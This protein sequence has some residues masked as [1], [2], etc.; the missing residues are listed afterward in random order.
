MAQN[1]P[2]KTSQ[3]ESDVDIQ[4]SYTWNNLESSIDSIFDIYLKAEES[5]Q[6]G[7]IS[8]VSSDSI[9]LSKAY[10]VSDLETNKTFDPDQ[11]H[12]MVASVAK[13]ITATAVFKLMEQ[14]K[15]QLDQPVKDIIKDITIQNPFDQP[16]LV[17]HLLTHTAGFD[18]SAM[19]DEVKD[20][21]KLAS[22]KDH[23]KKRLPPVVWEPGKFYNYS[24][25]GMVLLAYVVECASGL[26][27]D[28]FLR[29]NVYR[30][31][32]MD[33]SGFDYSDELL[34]NLFTRYRWKENEKRGLFLDGSYG[35]KYTNQIGASGFKTTGYDMA[36]FMQMY[37][38]KGM[39]QGIKVLEE[40]TIENALKPQF[41]YHD[42]MDS[43]QGLTW[44]IRKVQ[45]LTFYYHSG[46][47][48]GLESIL[49]MVPDKDI[50]YFFAS[51]NN[52]AS[53][54]KFELRDFLLNKL[55]SKEKIEKKYPSDF[56][57]DTDLKS[58]AGSYQ[59]MNDGYT[60]IESVSY[61]FGD[62]RKVK[63]EG[64]QFFVNGNVYEEVDKLLFR[65]KRDSLL[66]SFVIND[67]RAH[68]STGYGTFR[69]LKWYESPSLHLPAMMGCFAIFLS[70]VILWPIQYFR[71]RKKGN[72]PVYKVKRTIGI[73]AFLILF[74]F[75]LLGTTTQGLSL[76]FGAPSYLY[77]YFTLPIL[78]A[79]TFLI[80]LFKVPAFFKNSSV[81]I[82]GKVHFAVVLLAIVACLFIYNYY[83]LLGY[84]F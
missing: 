14:G 69:Q 9:L 47:D 22:L 53:N 26:P 49:V 31:L 6:G 11:T 25:R 45:D 18:D 79:L 59:Y 13:L 35:I 41:F 74:F 76:K 16:I 12:V 33:K 30:P 55:I 83:N 29:E 36:N 20:R 34:N 8:I 48:V 17:R 32:N 39:F 7:V 72:V 50:A 38:K 46:D 21:Q 71:K 77:F 37:L 73:A 81:S 54:L 57:S 56:V 28:Q 64:D 63:L 23:L 15:I 1:V 24:N 75:I 84:N 4:K 62:V 78:G 82:L 44:R 42:L 58:L 43:K 67:N 40:E 19:G 3:G 66:V 52:V 5:L 80:G 2:Q 27:F 65:R 60:T 10:G 68:Y 70:A 61:L 51:N